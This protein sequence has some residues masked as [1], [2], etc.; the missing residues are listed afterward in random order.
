[1][2]GIITDVEHKEKKAVGLITFNKDKINSEGYGLTC[3][4][5]TNIIFA[6][7]GPAGMYEASV[8]PRSQTG[9]IG[10]AFDAGVK[11]VNLTESQFGIASTKFRWNLSGSYQQVIPRYLSTS[12]DGKDEREFL[13]DSLTP[14]QVFNAVFLKGYQWPFDIKKVNDIGSSII[15]ILVYQE[16]YLKGRKV[17]MDF[18]Q[19]PSQFDFGLLNEETYTYLKRCNALLET[20]IKRLRAMNEPAYELYKLHEIDLETELL[21]INVCNQHSNGG[22]VGD[23][24]WESNVK[25]FFPVGE[26]NGSHG[27]YRPGG[28][29]LNSTQVGSNRA[30]LHIKFNYNEYPMDV[31]KFKTV[32]LRL[33][34][35]KYEWCSFLLNDKNKTNKVKLTEALKNLKSRMSKYGAFIRD[36]KLVKQ[37]IFECKNDLKDWYKKVYITSKSDLVIAFQ[38][39]DLLITQLTYLSAIDEYIN[40]NGCSRGSALIRTDQGNLPLPNLNEVFRFVIN[41]N[42]YLD[43]VCEVEYKNLDCEFEWI[44]VRPIPHENN[45]FENV[46]K[47]YRERMSKD[48]K[49]DFND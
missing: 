35:Q 16:T 3:F 25:H 1:V 13:F 41:E 49:S 6:A 39:Y 8:Y 22:L 40:K 28:S 33:L 19:N 4:N 46:W 11:G 5:C 31:D 30:S 9:S 48:E 44:K 45:W 23:I 21:E 37:T 32:S 34:N 17:F 15:D 26:V 43:Q 20:P 12:V 18:R 24:N 10:I 14:Q 7:G 29:A 38:Y 47:S 27:I 2:I 36:E 42:Q